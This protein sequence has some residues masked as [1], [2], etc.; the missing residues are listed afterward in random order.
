[1]QLLALG[2]VKLSVLYSYHPIFVA[3]KGGMFDYTTQVMIGALLW[4]G[5]SRS[6]SG[7]CLGVVPIWTHGAVSKISRLSAER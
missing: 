6:S 4:H 1:M 5:L 7:L 2:F 3:S